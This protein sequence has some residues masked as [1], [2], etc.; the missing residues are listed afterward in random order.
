M[1]WRA[2]FK[3]ENFMIEYDQKKLVIT[4]VD[5]SGLQDETI[6]DAGRD[7]NGKGIS[8][9]SMIKTLKKIKNG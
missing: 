3:T 9:D 4:P 7:N 1:D 8:V 6:F 5:L 2:K